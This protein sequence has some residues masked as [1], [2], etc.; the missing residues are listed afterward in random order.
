MKPEAA[1]EFCF[2]GAAAMMALFFW[3]GDPG[4]AVMVGVPLLLGGCLASLADEGAPFRA[5]RP[6]QS[7]GDRQTV[8]RRG[9]GRAATWQ[10]RWR[11]EISPSFRREH[12]E[13][14][15]DAARG[16]ERR[17]TPRPAAAR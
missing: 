12:L 1:A 7:G 15:I 2:T 13:T 6:P 16:Q 10:V 17:H 5:M 8:R 11:V 4:L 14:G 9:T 3:L